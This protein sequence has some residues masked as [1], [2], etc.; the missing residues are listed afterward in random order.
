[1][2]QPASIEYGTL[3]FYVIRTRINALLQK[4]AQ[5]SAALQDAA[6][7]AEKEKYKAQF[8]AVQVEITELAASVWVSNRQQTAELLNI[9]TRVL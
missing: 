3:Y 2:K 4:R 8:R 5:I 7:E 1:M 6:N 9:K